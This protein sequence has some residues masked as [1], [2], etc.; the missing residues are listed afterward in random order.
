[1]KFAI[2][3]NDTFIYGV[4]GAIAESRLKAKL[5]ILLPHMWEV[6]LYKLKK[7]GTI[8]VSNEY[9][10]YKFIWED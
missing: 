6:A 4:S 2:S 7:D 8:F 5:K 10:D 9:N 1:M 3:K